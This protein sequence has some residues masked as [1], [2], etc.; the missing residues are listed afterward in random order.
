MNIEYH[1][2]TVIFPT[3]SVSYH[4]CGFFTVIFFH[5]YICAMHNVKCGVQNLVR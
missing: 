5:P 2:F 4:D 1:Y 3:F